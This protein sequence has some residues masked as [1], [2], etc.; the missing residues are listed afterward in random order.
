MIRFVVTAL[1]GVLILLPVL[2]GTGFLFADF[3]NV[4]IRVGVAVLLYASIFRRLAF[5][6]QV[7]SHIGSTRALKVS[8]AGE[9]VAGFL[10][11]IGSLWIGGAIG[12]LGVFVSLRIALAGAWVFRQLS[13]GARQDTTE[14]LRGPEGHAV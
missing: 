8:A 2:V 10:G 9:A 5:G 1:R 12:W 7:Q 4:W 3:G 13:A 14:T 11:G 6:Q